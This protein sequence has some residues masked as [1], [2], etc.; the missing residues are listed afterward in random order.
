MATERKFW[1][2]FCAAVGRTD[3]S[4]ARRGEVVADHALGDHQLRAE[5]TKIFATR[6]TAAWVEVG[7]TADV[8][9][10][11]VNT[12]GTLPDDPHFAARTS[13]LPAERYGAD[14]LPLP[15]HLAGE[16]LAAPAPAATP[17]QHT[18]EVLA[19]LGVDAGELAT[20]REAGVVG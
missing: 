1:E 19:A 4:S 9:I 14:L 7:L 17:G 5:L 3:L 2:Q 18:G 16:E 6:S 10:A 20:L 11:P 15:V 13:W 12:P 8:P